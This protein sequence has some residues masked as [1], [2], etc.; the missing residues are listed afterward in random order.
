M[1]GTSQ[2]KNSAR[3]TKISSLVLLIIFAIIALSV[4][5]LILAAYMFA[6]D[7]VVGGWL[8]VIG[9]AGLILCIYVI[10]QLRKRVTRINIEVAPITTT[11]ECKKCGFKKVREFQRGDYIFKEAEPCQKCNEKMMI[12]AIYR[13]VQEKEKEKERSQI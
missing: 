11:I 13:E 4:A 8:I 9:L 1:N 12:T 3:S 5:A 6:K 2:E 7:L 10:L